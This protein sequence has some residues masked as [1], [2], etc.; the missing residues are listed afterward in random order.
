MLIRDSTPTQSGSSP[1]RVPTG[2]VR[3][4]RCRQDSAPRR[5]SLRRHEKG[6][7]LSCCGRGGP[8]QS[9]PRRNLVA[10]AVHPS[11]RPCWTDPD[12]EGRASFRYLAISANA[13]GPAVLAI[14]AI[15]LHTTESTGMAR[16]GEAL[17]GWSGT[18]SG[19]QPT[20]GRA[21]GTR[22]GL[23]DRHPVARLDHI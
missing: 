23:R 7:L 10:L 4:Y 6:E 17:E 13:L 22:P 20:G 15:V 19:T 18:T 5:D 8:G 3:H 2:P 16:N 14:Q 9:S 12:E 21:R 1:G 11:I